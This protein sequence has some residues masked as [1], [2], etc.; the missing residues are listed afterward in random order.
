MKNVHPIHIYASTQKYFIEFVQ[1]FAI[2]TT[3]FKLEVLKLIICILHTVVQNQ[4]LVIHTVISI[5]IFYFFLQS[6]I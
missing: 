6:P 2:T 1:F 5:F 4:K 3:I